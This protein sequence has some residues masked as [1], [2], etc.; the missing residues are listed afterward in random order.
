[1]MNYLTNA[2]GNPGTGGYAFAY[3]DTLGSIVCLDGC[4]NV[5]ST[6]LPCSGSGTLLCG[7][8]T[9]AENSATS[10][11]PYSI[12]GGGIGFA[13]N[14]PMGTSAASP[15][16]APFAATGSGIS[17][18]VSSLPT[19][20]LRLAID[21]GGAT[22]QYC[23]TLLTASGTVPWASFNT[24]CYDTPPDGVALTAAPSDAHQI[25]FQMPTVT[26]A[27]ATAD[28]CIMAVS[29]AP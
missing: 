12:Y 11:P 24:M 2:A 16:Q 19:N 18:T 3:D 9:L 7:H 17:Y 26:T 28:V 23:A 29:F 14:Q 6:L 25:E 22:I 20:G 27:T 8:G 4:P 1:M 15:V 21:H 5:D 13:L 10:T